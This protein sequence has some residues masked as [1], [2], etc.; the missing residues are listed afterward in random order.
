MALFSF[1]TEEAAARAIDVLNFRHY[2]N[3]TLKVRYAWHVKKYG[4]AI[5]RISPEESKFKSPSLHNTT[6]FQGTASPCESKGKVTTIPSLDRKYRDSM[7]MSPAHKAECL[8]KSKWQSGKAIETPDT[9]SGL[10]SRQNYEASFSGPQDGNVAAGSREVSESTKVTATV[11]REEKV[12]ENSS[13]LSESLENIS[14]TKEEVTVTKDS[15]TVRQSLQSSSP[16]EQGINTA[17]D[18]PE[19]SKGLESSIKVKQEAVLDVPKQHKNIEPEQG[20]GAIADAP[21]LDSSIQD[22]SQKLPRKMPEI[23][24][25]LATEPQTNPDTD[26]SI[27]S[28]AA[29]DDSALPRMS[30]K[31][32]WKLQQRATKAAKQKKILEKEQKKSGAKGVGLLTETSE[33][34]IASDV[35]SDVT[36]PSGSKKIPT[37]TAQQQIKLETDPQIS[38]DGNSQ[39]ESISLTE[40][41]SDAQNQVLSA[42]KSITAP[43]KLPASVYETSGADEPCS[44]EQ[45]KLDGTEGS[46]S[47]E[48]LVITPQKKKKKKQKQ[49]RKS[50]TAVQ[51]AEIPSKPELSPSEIE[52]VT[53][54]EILL[55][56]V[57]EECAAHSVGSQDG[58]TET[59]IDKETMEHKHEAIGLLRTESVTPTQGHPDSTTAQPKNAKS[60]KARKS[61]GKRKAKSAEAVAAQSEEVAQASAVP[62]D[63]LAEAAA[64][65]VQFLPRPET[66]SLANQTHDVLPVKI[67]EKEKG[68]TQTTPPIDSDEKVEGRAHIML[69]VEINKKLNGHKKNEFPSI[70]EEPHVCSRRELTRYHHLKDRDYWPQLSKIIRGPTLPNPSLSMNPMPENIQDLEAGEPGVTH[71]QP[72]ESSEANSQAPVNDSGVTKTAEDE[73]K[74]SSPDAIVHAEQFLQTLDKPADTGSSMVAKPEPL[75]FEISPYHDSSAASGSQELSVPDSEVVVDHANIS[76]GLSFFGQPVADLRSPPKSVTAFSDV[77]GRSKTPPL[78]PHT[79]YTRTCTESSSSPGIL[80]GDESSES[81]TLQSED[82]LTDNGGEEHATVTAEDGSP[83]PRM[84][85][86]TVYPFHPSTGSL[87]SAQL[88]WQAGDVLQVTTGDDGKKTLVNVSQDQRATNLSQV[89]VEVEN[90]RAYVERRDTR[91]ILPE[92][93]WGYSKCVWKY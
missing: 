90:E 64:I 28:L 13:K 92:E 38:L 10:S 31:V 4:D 88:P 19:L 56:Q 35:K 43:E 6:T 49:K 52:K 76:S 75:G 84:P 69:P 50:S 80:S 58:N 37:D 73:R 1:L 25:V 29:E 85:P 40:S 45:A 11:G 33:E 74:S 63:E 93:K 9:V 77:A 59:L 42:S 24:P 8:S 20:S 78:T 44:S 66:P 30:H 61:K 51:N 32:K 27:S 16:V 86:R 53:N 81:F 21:P 67:D 54:A 89:E 87:G 71:S 65:L 83:S 70:A 91:V 36:D 82:G 2:E 72:M 79:P 46:T 22:H 12:T 17:K 48:T 60:K 62:S 18:S 23:D 68:Q 14:T 26:A 7:E 47:S 55:D 57:H 39:S 41:S 15:L 34:I 3:M 5:H